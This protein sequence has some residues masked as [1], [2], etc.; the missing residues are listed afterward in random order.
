MGNYK[1]QVYMLV[2]VSITIT[3]PLKQQNGIKSDKIYTK[4]MEKDT[5]GHKSCTSLPLQRRSLR[6]SLIVNH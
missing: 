3:G 5:A 1:T 4:Y 2:H 6:G